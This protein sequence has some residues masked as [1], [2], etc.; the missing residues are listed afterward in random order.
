M[1]RN[2]NCETCDKSYRKTSYKAHLKS[3]YHINNANKNNIILD[4]ELTEKIK[5][6]YNI[7]DTSTIERIVVDV[8]DDRFTITQQL[9]KEGLIPDDIRDYMFKK[10]EIKHKSGMI[11]E[12]HHP[13]TKLFRSLLISISKTMSS[14]YFEINKTHPNILKTLRLNYYDNEFFN[15]Y[16][17]SILHLYRN[18]LNKI[19]FVACKNVY[20]YFILD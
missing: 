13:H 9:I 8:K 5:S 2:I 1:E 16:G 7:S 12:I 4:D 20:N 11:I 19:D 10:K 6:I 18:E 17:N 14:K 3:K 15:L